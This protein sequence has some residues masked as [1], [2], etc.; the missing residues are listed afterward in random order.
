MLPEPISGHSLI[1]LALIFFIISPSCSQSDPRQILLK[2]KTELAGSS[3]QVF[4]S[5]NENNPVCKF[6]GVVCDDKNSIT[7][8]NLSKQGLVGTLDFASICSL[9]S[10]E[11]ISLRSNLL[12]GNISSHLSDCTNL[13]LLDLGDNFFAGKFP[14]ISS[15]TQLQFLNLSLNG[16]SG[17]FPWNSLEKLTN[18]AYLSLGDNLFDRTPFPSE[19]LKL[20]KLQTL[21]LT[22][23]SIEGMIPEEI[24]NLVSLQTLELSFNYLVGAIPE[25]I[26]KLTKLQVLEL[27]DN[28][29]SGGFPVGFKNL[30]MLKELDVSNNSLDGDLSE[31][32]NLT[33]LVSLQLFENKFSGELP[34]E[35]GEFKF[36]QQFSIYHNMFT[37]ELPARIG[38]WADFQFI[39]VSENFLTG[40]IPPDMCKN[41]KIREIL[42]LQNKFTGGLPEAYANCSSLI[43]LRVSNNSLSGRVPDGFWGL[44]NVRLIDL[45]LNQF[46]GPV[47]PN[48]GEAKSLAQLF[49]AYNRFSGE[50]P[51]EISKV[52]SLVEMELMHN[53]FTGEI[54]STIGDL[55]QLNSLYLEGN[56]FSGTI[57][58]SLGSCVS[59]YDL[60]LAGNSL[61]GQ[62]PAS[63]GSLRELNSLNLSDNKLS[64]IIPASLSSP[65]L[66]LIDLSNNMLSGRVPESLLSE[67][68]DSSFAGNPGLCADGSKG[69]Q[70]CS[71]VPHS[72]G[73]LGVAKYCFIAGALVLVLSLACFVL[74][75]SKQKDCE[76]LINHRFPWDMKQFHIIDINEGEILR[77]LKQENL[78]GKGGSGNVYKVELAC[79]K[80]FA[81]KHMW[82]S[83]ISNDRKNHM[84]STAMLPKR[85][86]RWPEYE[87]E[88]ATLSSIRHVNVV[89]LYCSIT[90]E[91]SH[92]LVYEYMPKGSLW[93]QLHTYQ[94]TEMD[95]NV[96]YEIAVGAAKGLEYLHHGCD[97]PVIHR[98]VKSSNI[99]LD[100]EMKPKIADFGLAKIVQ[101]NKVMDSTHIIAGT[102]GYIAPEY[103]YT[104]N[105]TEKS[106]IYSF[107]VVLMELVTGKKPVEPEFGE[108]KDI[109]RWVND[110]MRSNDNLIALVDPNISDDFKG[111]ASNALTIAIRCTIRI[112][113]LRPS[114]RMVVQMLE[115][116]EP[117]F[118]IDIVIENDI[119]IVKN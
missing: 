44:P 95:W 24:G 89:K 2:F 54:P 88:V 60:N 51:E 22:N 29:L 45:S 77:S 26:T 70:Q 63:L 19:I 49:I 6:T 8:I 59:L 16:F 10:L 106:D 112:P 115:Q 31:L 48:I 43:R 15:L 50:L 65:R 21:Y 14:D 36:L 118:P 35:F 32:R 96:R 41:G 5:W 13:Q 62:I 56:L 71:P 76:S 109:V 12:H 99:L 34:R 9:E 103:G 83:G 92:L 82:K 98:D 4:S 37:G 80:Q 90:S 47:T 81:V 46:E 85:K 87:A 3:T 39:D 40:S 78:I 58:E 42:M 113:A 20:E 94:K 64:G 17:P 86:T 110:Q 18:L 101:L 28:E 111:F 33:R 108:N 84:S 11:K 52:S 57:P 75:K 25:G 61:S 1:L 102:H 107:G 114:M 30:V 117:R 7:E 72:S 27:Y 66:S 68:S 79:G 119:N 55:K 100:D 53:Q 23:S 38:S 104:L 93:D 73:G 91:D 97:R 105:V 69:L 116:I 74:V 67:A